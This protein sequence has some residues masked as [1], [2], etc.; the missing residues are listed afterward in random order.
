MSENSVKSITKLSLDG[1]CM[2]LPHFCLEILLKESKHLVTC[3]NMSVSPLI[4]FEAFHHHAFSVIS[5]Q[6][7]DE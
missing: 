3:L 2:C 6:P 5:V 1:L 7:S 4:Y